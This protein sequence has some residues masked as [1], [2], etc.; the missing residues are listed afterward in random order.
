[1]RKQLIDRVDDRKCHELSV[2]NYKSHWK[3][4]TMIEKQ[5]CVSK[6]DSFVA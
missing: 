1:M 6:P 3:V 2:K 5:K 4:P